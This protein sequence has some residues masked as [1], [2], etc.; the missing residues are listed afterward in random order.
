MFVK[1]MKS[2]KRLRLALIG[3]SG[4]GKTWTALAIANHLGLSTGLID[5]EDGSS[6]LYAE[7][8][9]FMMKQL[10]SFE[11]GQYIEAISYAHEFETLIIDSMSHAWFAELEMV[12]GRFDNWK[13]VRPLERKLMRTILRF[14]GHVIVT[15]RSKTEWTTEKVRNKKGE[16]VNAPVKIGT[17]PVQA[18]G[19]EYEFDLVGELNAVGSDHTLTFTKSRYKGL[20]GAA[21]VNPGRDVADI[22][23]TW[24]TDG[25]PLPAIP[26]TPEARMA[27]IRNAIPEGVTTAQIKKLIAEKFAPAKS[28]R[29][30]TSEQA[31][32]LIALLP[33][34]TSTAA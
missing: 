16:E 4:S 28:S 19:I 5:T 12:G 24:L 7:E 33:S 34:L 9:D 14:P 6:A 29:E 1:P 10:E 11:P 26:E 27:R 18:S 2:Q 8:F 21:F 13:N 15:M 3:P 17:G 32:E 22:L 30:L 25:A 20:D 31:D 23:T